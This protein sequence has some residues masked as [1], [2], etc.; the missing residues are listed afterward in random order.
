MLKKIIIMVFLVIAAAAAAIFIYRYQIIQYSVESFI[1]KSLPPY[2]QIDKIKFDFNSSKIILSGF[3]VANPPRFSAVDLIHVSEIS[4]KYKMK[5]KTILDGFEVF[6]PILKDPLVNIE[7]LRNGEI[8]L[9]EMKDYVGEASGDKPID[10]AAGRKGEPRASGEGG[11]KLSDI[12]KLPHKYTIRN[13][14]IVFMDSLPYTRPHILTLDDIN[15]SASI[16]LNSYYTALL[17]LSSQGAACLNGNKGE[18][19]KWTTALDPRAPKLTMSNR[20]EVSN[21]DILVFEPYY[22]RYSPFIFKKGRFSG[23]LIFDFDNGNIGS[24][25]EIRLSHLAFAV[26]PDYEN[27]QFWETTVPDLVKYFSSSFGEIVFDFKIK[28]D[29]AHP[30]FYLGPISK[31]ALAAM[32]IDKI[33]GAVGELQKSGGGSEGGGKARE[34]IDLFRE[35]IKKQ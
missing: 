7:R 2:I 6:D 26:K 27:A 32:A 24:S 15:A 29:M 19:I 33:A 3:R 8:N 11:K 23:T 25:N 34:Y 30:Q 18:T 1:R 28:G 14:R 16:K 35:L 5:G 17:A 31:Q 21:L 13:G 9:L 4:C 12:I 10:S 22:D 20:F